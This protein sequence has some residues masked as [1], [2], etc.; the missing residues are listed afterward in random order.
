MH[1]AII[2]KE[3]LEQCDIVSLIFVNGIG[4]DLH[5]KSEATYVTKARE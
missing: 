3:I 1:I 5:T 4:S 2:I